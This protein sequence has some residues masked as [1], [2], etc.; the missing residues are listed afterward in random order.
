LTG[1]PA[2]D[3]RKQ[4]KSQTSHT[5]IEPD[6]GSFSQDD[7]GA[8][9]FDLE[10][11]QLHDGVRT[12]SGDVD[13]S[14]ETGSVF[15]NPRDDPMLPTLQTQPNCRS[16]RSRVSP[17]PA[18]KLCHSRSL[19]SVEAA[20]DPQASIVENEGHDS[21][22]DS[23]WVN[24]FRYRRLAKRKRQRAAA[25]LRRITLPRPTIRSEES[26]K[27]LPASLAKAKIQNCTSASKANLWQN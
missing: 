8:V 24:T 12:S 6:D 21:D 1:F 17:K 20:H 25:S 23:G 13:E 18:T 16:E 27:T 5:S 10:P 9:N 3:I 2:K 11:F 22:S 4:Y 15:E 19:R 7:T 26:T 14:I